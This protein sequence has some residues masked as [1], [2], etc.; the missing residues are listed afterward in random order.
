MIP[1]L[2]S[3]PTGFSKSEQYLAKIAQ[4]TFLTFWSHPNLFRTR[5]KELADLIVIFGDSVVIFS[6][7]SCEYKAGE[8][9]WSRWYRRAVLE[10]AKQL[11]RAE[12]WIREHP[13]EVFMD[14][15]CER[16]FPL[17]VPQSPSIY[18]VAVATGARAAAIDVTVDGSLAIASDSDGTLEFAIGDIDKTKSF[19]HVFDDIC[20]TTLLSELDTAADFIMY[21]K[22]RAAFLRS[23]PIT[24]AAGELELLTHYLKNF[25]D[26]EHD[27]NIPSTDRPPTFIMLDE[28]WQEFTQSAPYNRKKAAEAESYVWDRLIENVASHADRGTLAVG[29]EHGLAGTEGLLRLLASENRFKRR[30]LAK[31][32]NELRR[33]A[34]TGPE[35]VRIRTALDADDDRRAYVFCIVRRRRNKDAEY[36][37]N[38]RGLMVSHLEITK[39]RRQQLREIIGIA[40]APANDPDESVDI[41][42][43]VY[44]AWSDEERENA[45]RLREQLGWSSDTQSL[46]THLHAHEYPSAPVPDTPPRRATRPDRDAKAETKR[47]RQAQKIA[48]K[49]NRR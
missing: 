27:F 23:G 40:V 7:K 34:T 47:K 36:R 3:S 18:L 43:R 6:D 4:R 5:A 41:A 32:F 35:N 31:G 13:A 9:G 12:R 15:K 28:D 25:H 20:L 45:E 22:K 37:I 26:G 21:L 44:D 16:R 24:H 8:H 39:L 46:E 14:A 49:K 33:L 42:A 17:P 19:I 38:R 29:Q 11:W 2:H 10:S 1:S 48:R 30:L